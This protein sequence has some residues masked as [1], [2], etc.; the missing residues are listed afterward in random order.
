MLVIKSQNGERNINADIW[1][2]THTHTHQSLCVFVLLVSRHSSQICSE[3]VLLWSSRWHWGG[4]RVLS[5]SSSNISVMAHHQSTCQNVSS[6]WLVTQFWEV[7]KNAQRPKILPVQSPAACSGSVTLLLL[8]L[9][10][11]HASCLLSS[12]LTPPTETSCGAP[13]NTHTAEI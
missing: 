5:R 12:W 7:S 9:N 13:V 3:S 4:Q 6:S 1:E 8:V 2:N 11:S 10:S